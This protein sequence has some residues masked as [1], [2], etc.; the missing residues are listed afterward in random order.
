MEE[1]IVVHRWPF[2]DLE[3]QVAMLQRKAKQKNVILAYD[4]ALYVAQRF[5]SNGAALMEVFPRFLD[6]SPPNGRHLTL[7][8]A[9]QRLGKLLDDMGPKGT[10]DRIEDLFKVHSLREG[11]SPRQCSATDDSPVILSLMRIREKR[12]LTRARQQFEVNMR[13]SE[14]EDLAR[15][16]V[17]ERVFEIVAMKQK[18]QRGHGW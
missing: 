5:R 17:Y 1:Q 3:K 15:L 10:V 11:T 12:D 7:E 9:K 18:R 13:E 14:R 8:F 6:C 16:D 2:L 4:A